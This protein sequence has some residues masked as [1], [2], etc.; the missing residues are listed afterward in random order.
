MEAFNSLFQKIRLFFR[1]CSI[2]SLLKKKKKQTTNPVLQYSLHERAESLYIYLS[3]KQPHANLYFQNCF[4]WC[5]ILHIS[6]ISN[7]EMH[8]TLQLVFYAA[9]GFFSSIYVFVTLQNCIVNILWNAALADLYWLVVFTSFINLIC[10][11]I[12]C[13]LHCYKSIFINPFLMDL[14]HLNFLY[15]FY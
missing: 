10:N 7:T 14:I 15:T 12:K 2:L 6:N 4:K 13:V 3:F 5:A 9:E 11:T 8:I 1:N